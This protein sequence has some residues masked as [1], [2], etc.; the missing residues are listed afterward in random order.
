MASH[1]PKLLLAKIETVP[2]TD[3]LPVVGTDA[4]LI[5]NDVKVNPLNINYVPL[6]YARDYMGTDRKLVASRYMT[7]SFKVYLGSSGTPLGTIPK[8]GPLVRACGMKQT[9]TAT[10]KVDYTDDVDAGFEFVT[11]YFFYAGKRHRMVYGVGKLKGMAASGGVPTLDMEFTGLCTQLPDDNTPGA[12]VYTGWRDPLPINKANTTVSLHGYTCSMYDFSF[13]LGNVTPYTNN[14]NVEDMDLTDRNRTGSITILDPLIAQ[15]D[16]ETIV[17]NATLGP[18]TLV[19]GTVA[20]D[21]VEIAGTDVQLESP[22]YGD[23]DMR[24][25]RKLGLIFNRTAKGNFGV[26]ITAR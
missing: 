12:A 4:C 1:R 25:T 5:L 22:D 15:K 6:E 23:K 14:P 3:S 2:G 24:V 8:W 17:A 13:D 11:L 7:I 9:V 10:T 20:G 26:R 18:F 19:N 21:I 16:Y